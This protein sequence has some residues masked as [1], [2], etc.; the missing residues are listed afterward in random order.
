MR[1]GK[2]H[3]ASRGG[4]D[5]DVAAYYILTDAYIKQLL[6]DNPGLIL[7]GELYCHG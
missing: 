3:T 5:Y 1:D 6:T 4:Q 2:L 7:D